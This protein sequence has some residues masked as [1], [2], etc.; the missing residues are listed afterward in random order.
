MQV[1]EDHFI[2]PHTTELL[3]PSVLTSFQ[4]R[5]NHALFSLTICSEQVFASH[6][7]VCSKLHLELY[8]Y[9]NLQSQSQQ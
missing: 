6:C 1:E 2:K 8:E 9:S 5:P 3:T 4:V 7:K